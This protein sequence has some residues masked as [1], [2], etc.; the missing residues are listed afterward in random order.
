MAVV[1]RGNYFFVTPGQKCYKISSN[2]TNYFQIGI[3]NVTSYYL[4]AKI[5]ENE[6]VVSGKLLNSDGKLACSIENNYVSET[7]NVV[8][9][10]TSSGYRLKHK[11]GDVFFEITVTSE[12]VCL[13]KGKV[14][15]EN[16]QVVAEDKNED[17]LVYRGPAIVGK[18]GNTI[19]LKIG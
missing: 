1:M 12:N 3:R 4:E 8:K 19:G 13:L 5:A 6:F 17:F 18:S 16:G 10:M 15:D 11:D 9:E 14:F 2:F 7:E